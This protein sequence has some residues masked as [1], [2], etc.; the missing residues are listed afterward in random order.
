MS[1][2]VIIGAGAAGMTAALY[3]LRNGKSVKILEEETFGGQ[4]A[5]SPRVEN[6]PTIK[7]TRNPVIYVIHIL[8]VQATPTTN[9]R[10]GYL[11][12]A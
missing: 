12:R 1:D 9:V 2:I 7:A 4:I 5:N 3:A 6:F 8:C 10:P 11:R